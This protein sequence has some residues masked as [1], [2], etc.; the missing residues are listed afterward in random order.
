MS[1]K[2]ITLFGV[3]VTIAEE[4]L[5]MM[6]NKVIECINQNELELAER[7]LYRAREIEND[8]NSAH[9]PD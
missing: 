9:K 2:T 6:C 8:L 4:I 5:V 1:E 3:P 7:Y